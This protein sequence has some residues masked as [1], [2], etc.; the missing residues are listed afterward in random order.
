MKICRETSNHKFYTFQERRSALTLENTKLI[1]STKVCVD[2]CEID[3]DGIRCD[4][5]HLA[6][7]IEMYIELKGQD[8][9]HAISQIER[10]IQILSENPQKKPKISYV[11]CTRSPLSSTEIQNY[12]RQFRLKFNS[13]LIIKSSPFKDKY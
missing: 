10:T 8:I 7:N 4:F 13:K 5:L 9:K 6:N 1:V 12:E 3:D 11:I 2:G